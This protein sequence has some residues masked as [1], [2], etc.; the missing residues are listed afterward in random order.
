MKKRIFLT[1]LISLMAIN[2]VSFAADSESTMLKAGKPIIKEVIDPNTKA[3][4]TQLVFMIKAKP[5]KVW[6]VLM[7]CEKYPEFMPVKT[8]KY[9]TRGGSYDI[10]HVEPEAPAM[11]NVSYDMKRTYNKAD[12][13]ISFVKV[14]GK[15]KSANG[16]WKFEPIDSKYTKVTYVNNVDIGVPVP[17]FVRDY[18]AKGSLNKLAEGVKKRVES[19]GTWKR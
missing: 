8:Y 2:T 14:A 18:F 13:K 6:D 4:E 16:W 19:N 10:V 9:K 7:D 12:W 17:G 5:E 3:S 1:S 15:I 11:F